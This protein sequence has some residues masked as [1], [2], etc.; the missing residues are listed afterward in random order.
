MPIGPGTHLGPYEILDKVGAGG[1][2]DVYRAR[3]ARLERD[4]AVKVLPEHL[5][6]NARALERFEREAKAIAALTHPNILAIHDS[7][8]EE[9]VSFAVMEL[10]EGETLRQRLAAAPL[11]W[12]R[13]VEIGVDIAEGLAAAHAKGIV[14]RDLKPENLFITD[15]GHVKILD[16]GLARLTESAAA[17]ALSSAPTEE[18]TTPGT[19]LG[20]AG[21]MSPEQARA[22]TAG[23]ASDI[24]SLG[25]VLHEMLTGKRTFARGS[26]AEA[27]AAI[28]KEDPPPPS[29]SDPSIPPALD[30]LVRHC[31]EKAPGERFQSARDLAFAL[32]AVLAA[33]GSA[34]QPPEDRPGSARDV[35]QRATTARRQPMG[36]RE[37]VV[38]GVVVLA[39]AGLWLWRSRARTGS[40]PGSAEA[41]SI[42]VLPFESV[43]GADGD[44]Y[45]ADGVAEAVTTNL[46]RIPG[47]MV[48]ARNSAFRYKGKGL[49]VTKVG[50][51]LNVRYL[52]K[53]DV[54][55]SGNR[56]RV[57][58][59]LIDASTGSSL[60]A[61]D[62]EHE[63]KGV[64]AVQD[65]IA[66]S[67]AQAIR[68]G[69]GRAAS[70]TP[71]RLPPDFEVYDL[72]LR[73]RAAWS[74]RTSEDI[75]RAIDLFQEAIRRDPAFA[76]AYA[77]L[78]DAL[79]I[80]SG[81]LNIIPRSEMLPRAKGAAERAL[82]LD[83]TLAEAHA[84]LG[85][86]HTKALRWNEA[87][88]ELRR[89]IEL[90]SSYATAHHWYALLLLAQRGDLE[91]AQ[92][93]ISL[94]AELDPFAPALTGAFAQILYFRGDYARAR[95]RGQRAHELAP[96]YFGPLLVLSRIDS[97]DG[98]RQDALAAAQRAAGLVPGNT[99]ASAQLA[100]AYAENGEAPRARTILAE[101]ERQ[102]EPCV[103]CIV[104]VQLALGD[105][106]AA[107]ARVDRGGF[108][109]GSF[110]FPKVDPAYAAYR[111]DAR[112]S[113]ILQAARL[114]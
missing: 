96:Q 100:R 48:I 76:E 114:E 15:G 72:Y 74:R 87:E 17:A 68:P 7:G 73:G 83:S 70:A 29:A 98:R 107:V 56:L 102:G 34:P 71:R 75:R 46:A 25:C 112:F 40:P 62:Y 105:L 69:L 90:N 20:T 67:V 6:G 11:P 27:L 49:D 42:A 39:G 33:S 38:L 61:E 35:V 86:L 9:G 89:A 10:L 78:A 54:Q 50:A 36:R 88:H 26:A 80:G 77:G 1:M 94:A 64:F 113:R 63:L 91:E 65:D 108:T 59:Q 106:D 41:A 24:F 58:A 21:Y 52:V 104:D 12:R 13:A 97:I 18:H 51:E 5:S 44:E 82:L 110:Y 43:R 60:W 23:P 84:S 31:L 57:H 111:A 8:S 22:E 66:R 92:R 19:V 30:A 4:V 103:E 28:L 55:R 95:L 47:F 99:M 37:L 45:F 2:G 32:R 16:F 85:N 81:Q 14:H 101:L 3:H 93:E 53:G 79:I 109:P